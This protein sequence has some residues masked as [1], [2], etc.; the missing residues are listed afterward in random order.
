MGFSSSS[1]AEAGFLRA[2]SDP[3]FDAANWIQT[4]KGGYGSGSITRDVMKLIP[5]NALGMDE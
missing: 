5:N 3:Y 1:A 2:G 4:T